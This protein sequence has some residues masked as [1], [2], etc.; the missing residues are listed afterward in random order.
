MPDLSRNDFARRLAGLLSGLKARPVAVPGCRIDVYGPL[1]RLSVS[2]GRGPVT[3]RPELTGPVSAYLLD[4]GAAP[5][6]PRFF[7]VAGF[8]FDDLMQGARAA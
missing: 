4:L 6:P 5:V 1:S 2:R 7:R 3:L 8:G